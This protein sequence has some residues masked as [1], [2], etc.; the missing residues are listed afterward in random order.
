MAK[1]NKPKGVRADGTPYSTQISAKSDRDVTEDG[2]SRHLRTYAAH[3]RLDSPYPAPRNATTRMVGDEFVWYRLF[4]SR[5]RGNAVMEAGEW[6]RNIKRTK[7]AESLKGKATHECVVIDDP[8]NECSYATEFTPTRSVNCLLDESTIERV[9]KE[10]EGK[11]KRA[12]RPFEN[13]GRG[14]PS[15]EWVDENKRINTDPIRT[16]FGVYND[17]SINGMKDSIAKAVERA[18]ERKRNKQMTLM[19][20]LKNQDARLIVNKMR[21]NG[22]ITRDE[23][24]VRA[25]RSDKGIK[26]HAS[27]LLAKLNK[28]IEGVKKTRRA[29][30]Q[31]KKLKVAEE[32]KWILAQ[33]AKALSI[34]KKQSSKHTLR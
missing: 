25:S 22:L 21:K 7:N 14:H 16:G 11:L 19:Q 24:K 15:I 20:E 2:D 8:W 31:R 34:R 30:R 4:Q 6:F 27:R 28:E 32:A 29:I 33:E 13:N 17:P 18:S 3:I 9:L 26:R 1:F 12:D 5:G 10:S 23:T